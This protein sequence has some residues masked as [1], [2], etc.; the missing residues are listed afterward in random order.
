VNATI[1]RYEERKRLH[2]WWR[3]RSPKKLLPKEARLLRFLTG[4]VEPSAELVRAELLF[5]ALGDP[6]GGENHARPIRERAEQAGDDLSYRAL[7]NLAC[8]EASRSRNTEAGDD[9][10][11]SAIRYLALSLRRVHGRPR[12]EIARWAKSDPALAP[13]RKMP[14]FKAMMVRYA[15][16]KAKAKPARSTRG[17][18]MPPREA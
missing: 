4:T 14:K 17:R 16:H 11:G 5:S 3:P 7:Y 13:L 2:R 1:D 12:K 15:P 10:I 6:V 9:A 18:R 8:Y